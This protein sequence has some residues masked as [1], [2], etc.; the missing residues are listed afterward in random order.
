M[1]GP[2]IG[3]KM[4][5]LGIVLALVSASCFASLGIF[6]KYLYAAG[7][8][9]LAALSW[10]FIV[11]AMVLWVFL[12]LSGRWRLGW[13][14]FRVAFLLGIFGFS[15][16]AGLFFGTVRYLDV[17]LAALLLY[18]YPALVL[19]MEA[20]L[21][22]RIPSRVQ[23]AAVVL[24]LLGAVLALQPGKGNVSLV[25]VLLG[26][27]CAIW[28]SAYLLL[29]QRVLRNI[30]SL[31]ATGSLSLG[32]ICVF[33]PMALLRGEFVVPHN[34]NVWSLVLGVATVATV[35]PIVTLFASIRRIGAAQASLVSSFEIVATVLLGS[36][37][38]HEE[39]G[40]L[41]WIGALMIG[42]AV[43]LIHLGDKLPRALRIPSS[44]TLS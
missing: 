37:I 6:A 10:R 26:L 24:S 43:L 25:G 3:D 44:R 8:S 30:D 35:V 23:L 12:F 11:S 32:A 27:S 17:S 36:V 19:G 29:S 20:F 5:R 18:L 40:L 41:R 38:L 22:R 28:Y 31:F 9:P 42:S 34:L 2:E 4:K 21:L 39:L 13:K 14:N 16:Q 1:R 15:T 33:L 7:L